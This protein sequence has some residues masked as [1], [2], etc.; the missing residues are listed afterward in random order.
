MRDP[1]DENRTVDEIAVIPHIMSARAITNPVGASCSREYTRDKHRGHFRAGLNMPKSAVGGTGF[2]VSRRT[3][4]RRRFSPL[5]LSLIDFF[6]EYYSIHVPMIIRVDNELVS[7]VLSRHKTI[8]VAV[9]EEFSRNRHAGR[10]F[11]TTEKSS[12][13]YRNSILRSWIRYYRDL[14]RTNRRKCQYR[15]R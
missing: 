7:A 5:T 8:G 3:A 10:D 15:I 11:L 9:T 12:S 4:V 2:E 14:T 1:C 13:R 6:A